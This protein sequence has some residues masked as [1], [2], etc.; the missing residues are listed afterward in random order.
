MKLARD[1]WPNSH[2]LKGRARL[3]Y[4]H[5]DREV[6][7]TARAS[8]PRVPTIAKRGPAVS[9]T[10]KGASAERL[11]AAH[12][13]LSSTGAIEVCEAQPDDYGADFLLTHE[14]YSSD[15]KIEV[16]S[17]ARE[18]ARGR[19]EFRFDL[20]EVP[21]DD[22]TWFALGVE[23]GAQP[24]YL[25]GVAWL[26]PAAALLGGRPPR[27][28][29]KVSVSLDPDVVSQ[30]NRY[31]VPLE[32]LAVALRARFEEA[33]GRL[34]TPPPPSRHP[35][36]HA[37]TNAIGLTVESLFASHLLIK[38]NSQFEVYRPAPDRGID[39]MVRDD[40]GGPAMRLQ[41]KGVAARGPDGW[42]HVRIR[43]RTFKQSRLNF[44][45]LFEL[46]PATL[47]L[48]DLFWL[49]RSDELARLAYRSGKDY[50]FEAPPNPANTSDKYARHRYSLKELVPTV[51][52]LLEILRREGPDA[53]LP[54][55]RT[56]VASRA[57][58]LDPGRFAPKG[59]KRRA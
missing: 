18:A 33:D 47:T 12:L 35:H 21:A 25:G 45:A 28:T 30:W 40:R 26:F 17:S 23:L 29:Y 41:I 8:L 6:H 58:E 19:L 49:L 37:T 16:K 5:L 59:R 51:R 27:G 55:A 44:I 2:D 32:E 42:V 52:T 54:S 39:R 22:P 20:A 43:A 1:P 31:R 11:A 48:R 14:G 4:H 57:P 9:P 53:L 13:V 50:I 3:G 15:L 24:A 10:Q 56:D 36:R 34:G 46:D 7:S 38:G